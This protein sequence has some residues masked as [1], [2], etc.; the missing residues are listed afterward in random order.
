MSADAN[1]IYLPVEP[2]AALFLAY[3]QIPLVQEPQPLSLALC[4]EHSMPLSR[5][6]EGRALLNSRQ[7]RCPPRHCRVTT[8]LCFLQGGYRSSGIFGQQTVVRQA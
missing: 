2:V 3:L 8:L 5:L 1:N 4:L 6:W 7:G